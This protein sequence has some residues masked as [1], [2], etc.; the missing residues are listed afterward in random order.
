MAQEKNAIF[1]KEPA[2]IL[3]RQELFWYNTYLKWGIEN[4]RNCLQC[5]FLVTS[6][7]SLSTPT[8]SGIIK[9]LTFI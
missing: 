8:V 9:F 7:F 5:S 2:K 4:S 1:V 6:A 3:D